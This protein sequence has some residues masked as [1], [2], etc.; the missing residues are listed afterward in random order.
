MYAQFTESKI[1]LS[2]I[3]EHLVV[4]LFKI[5][6][7]VIFIFTRKWTMIE[8]FLHN[9]GRVDSCKELQNNEELLSQ[10]IKSRSG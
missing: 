10:N 7:V 2:L 5:S 3:H 9:H 6:C 8:W 1:V 4:Y